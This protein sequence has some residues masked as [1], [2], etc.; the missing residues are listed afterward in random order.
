MLTSALFLALPSPTADARFGGKV[1]DDTAS[2]IDD[3]YSVGVEF[4]PLG[5]APVRSDLEI[6]SPSG[7]GPTGTTFKNGRGTRTAANT[8]A[9]TDLL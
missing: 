6:K 8:E 1:K 4:E 2:T 5:N 3:D 7:S 9:T